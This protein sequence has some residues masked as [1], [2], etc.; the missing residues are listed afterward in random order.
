MRI[1]RL[2]IKNFRGIKSLDWKVP[3]D[4][5]LIALVGAGD[6]GKSTILEAIHY[7]LGDRWLVPFSDID[8]Y[9]VNIDEPI[10]IRAAV[11][12]VPP[13]LKKESA[14]GLWLSGVDTDGEIY[15]DPEDQYEPGLLVEL[16]VDAGLEPKWTVVRTDGQAQF[17][18]ATQRRA[19]STFKVDD[20]NDTQLRWSRTSALGRMSAEDG[21]E[22]EALAAASRAARD[23]LADHENSSLA[24]LATRVQDRAN[25]IGGGNFRDIKPGLDTSRSSMGAGLAL[26]EDVVPLTSYGLGSRRLASLAVQQ[27]GAG[28][29]SV[30]VVDEIE[31]GLEPHRAVRLLNYLLSDEDYSQVIVTTHSPVVVEQAHIENLA[32]IVTVNGVVAVTSLGGASEPLQRVR[33]SRPSSL[34]AR[35]I[36]VAEGATEY[37][38]LLEL[39]DYW[40][41]NRISYGLSTAAG[42]GVAIQDSQ[43]GPEV[44]LR[45]EAL[46]AIGYGAAAFMDNDDRGSDVAVETARAAGVVIVRWDRG[47]SLEGQ[48]CSN[49][50]ANSLTSLV[51][52]GVELRGGEETVL[53]DLNAIDSAHP[54]SSFKVDEWIATGIL[55]LEQARER[56]ARAASKRKWFKN[57]EG[58]RA[59]G[60]WLINHSGEQELALVMAR[61]AEVRTFI[62]P[63]PSILSPEVGR[64]SAGEAPTLESAKDGASRADG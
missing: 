42:E 62:Y 36:V 58:G 8:F 43:G 57:V 59:L 41:I 39:V 30:A 64:G 25:K 33:R 10:V 26:Y 11:I 52:L 21:S 40:D 3:V 48:I 13:L 46:A 1:R 22:R 16:K 51:F 14:F 60:A 34:L 17:L 54:V 37:G 32:T 63:E 53:Q 4:Q 55:P 45:A 28:S 2:W 50:D 24:E 49:L 35:R 38:L 7:L 5:R 29:R 23:A 12:D 6:S 56:V 44:P 20:R 9:G 18:S 61:I 15:Q 31:D 27:L 47:L 19:F